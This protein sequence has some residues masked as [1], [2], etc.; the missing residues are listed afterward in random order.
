MR[1]ASDLAKLCDCAD[2]RLT[3]LYLLARRVQ[4][5]VQIQ[6]DAISTFVL[7]E[8]ANV[9]STFARC[10]YVSC[11]CGARTATGHRITHGQPAIYDE[12]TAILHAV[13]LLK[14]QAIPRSAPASWRPT[15]LQEPR[16]LSRDTLGRLARDLNTSNLAQIQ[17]ALAVTTTA[18]DDLPT[19]RNFFAH[20]SRH[21]AAEVRQVA[22]RYTISP[23]VRPKDICHQSAARMPH[24][25]VS[26]WIFDIREVVRLLR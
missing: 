6:D 26:D 5:P 11:C 1:V 15:P 4:T 21:T 18:F 2:R 22:R 9:W 14:P 12:G 10:Y 25:L 17:S 13:R 24:S 16:W 8:S 3:K 19:V 7:V 20:R 23:L